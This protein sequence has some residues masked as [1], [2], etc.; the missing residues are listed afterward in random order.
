[1]RSD[2][3]D[4]WAWAC[5][6][7]RD[8]FLLVGICSICG[9][10]FSFPKET[11]SF[12]STFQY[13]GETPPDVDADESATFLFSFPSSNETH[14]YGN[15][16]VSCE[17]PAGLSFQNWTLRKGRRMI[18]PNDIR[19]DSL[20]RRLIAYYSANGEALFSGTELSLIVKGDCSERGVSSGERE[21]ILSI[22]LTPQQATARVAETC[23]I[24]EENFPVTLRCPE[25]MCLEGGMNFYNFDLERINVGQIDDK[26]EGL[27]TQRSQSSIQTAQV[28]RHTQR[29]MYGDTLRALFE[30]IVAEI[31]SPAFW[32]HGFAS[33]RIEH[34]EILEPVG[35]KLTIYDASLR[36]YLQCDQ[37]EMSSYVEAPN[38]MFFYDITPE[39][40]AESQ[41]SFIGYVFEG[42]DSVW[43]ETLYR[44]Q[45]NLGDSV[46]RAQV[47][48]RFYLSDVANPSLRSQ[49]H[50]CGDHDAAFTALGFDFLLGEPQQIQVSYPYQEISQ[51]YHFL[52]GGSDIFTGSDP[53]PFEYRYFGHIKRA[54]MSLPPHYEI[55][56][57]ALEQGGEVYLLANDQEQ[58]ESEMP[59]T[60]SICQTEQYEWNLEESFL[61][62]R[63]D[64]I[65]GDGE[66]E[67]KISVRL[68]P[69]CGA[70][71]DQLEKIKWSF[72]YAHS[73]WLNGGKESRWYHKEPD[74][75]HYQVPQLGMTY[76]DPACDPDSHHLSWILSI[77]NPQNNPV[78]SHSW[79]HIFS[80]D[81]GVEVNM[82]VDLQQ[83]DTIHAMEDL[84]R[85]GQ[86]QPGEEEMYEIFIQYEDMPPDFLTVYSGFGCNGYP[87]TVN[88]QSDSYADL[89]LFPNLTL[90]Q[91]QL[92]EPGTEAADSVGS[93]MNVENEVDK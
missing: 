85:L 24:K 36:R 5:S 34:G 66:F 63:G 20:S 1:M 53:F 3:Q 14:I 52:I 58:P 70:S 40:I 80:P 62:S 37:I 6:L 86:L 12:E 15:Y 26:L 10:C 11:R 78:A 55:S 61:N 43:L 23:L 82:V 46:L 93:D 56:S 60:S 90:D 59:D 71:E 76:L 77:R 18:H 51:P 73:G 27:A 45:K 30:G 7:L 64:G 54:Q 48:N 87:Q 33:S 79:V 89:D 88:I 72:T 41:A 91:L 31:D 16:R 19:F 2:Y 68:I 65:L 50:Q 47:E 81:S 35:A 21:V 57:L 74:R 39:K 22:C 29:L 69:T 38:R 17:I 32:Q 84:Y 42:R 67:G 75:L 13:F 4:L 49:V 25:N 8:F 92:S 28:S 44:V 9:V 83:G